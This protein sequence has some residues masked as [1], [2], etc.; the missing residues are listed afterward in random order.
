LIEDFKKE[1]SDQ[2]YK[3]GIKNWANPLYFPRLLALSKW[4]DY[5]STLV[6]KMENKPVALAQPIFKQMTN[7][8]TKKIA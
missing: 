4:M 7:I 3:K 6:C 1:L 5:T 8:M 2:D